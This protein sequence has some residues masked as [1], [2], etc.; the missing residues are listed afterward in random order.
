MDIVNIIISFIGLIFAAFSLFT[1]YKFVARIKLNF[2]VKQIE[3]SQTYNG[4][5]KELQEHLKFLYRDKEIKNIGISQITII[6]NGF[7]EAENFEDYITI[8]SNAEILRFARDE[9]TTPNLDISYG[10]ENENKIFLNVNYLNY[11][12]KIVVNIIYTIKNND[13]DVYFSVNARCKGCSVVTQ[14]FPE[15]KKVLQKFICGIIVALLA[16]GMNIYYY[17]QT[18]YIQKQTKLVLN[19]YLQKVKLLSNPDISN[20]L[21]ENGVKCTDLLS[22]CNQTNASLIE[23]IIHEDTTSNVQSKTSLEE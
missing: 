10:R 22:I 8:N 12:D 1:A 19:Q 13:T 14:I 4:S 5:N 7:K 6:N 15:R 21:M 17:M 18:Q 16:F 2:F 9:K 20:E 23:F 3:F 11:H